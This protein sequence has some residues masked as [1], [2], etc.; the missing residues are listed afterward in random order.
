MQDHNLSIRTIL[1]YYCLYPAHSYPMINIVSVLA[2]LLYIAVLPGPSL[3]PQ[4][5]VDSV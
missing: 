2:N 3:V 4:A 1:R 5:T